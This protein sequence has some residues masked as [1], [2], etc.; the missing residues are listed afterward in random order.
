MPKTTIAAP[1]HTNNT[2]NSEARAIPKALNNSGEDPADPGVY[3][4]KQLLHQ[5]PVGP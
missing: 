1:T 5:S 2:L 4:S 3:E